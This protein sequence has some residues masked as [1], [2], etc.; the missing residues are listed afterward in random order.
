MKTLKFKTKEEASKVINDFVAQEYYGWSKATD[1]DG[2]VTW[3]DVDDRESRVHFVNITDDF[4]KGMEL[5][6]KI[7]P[8]ADV[9]IYNSEDFLTIAWFE[10]DNDRPECVGV[11][12]FHSWSFT[13]WCAIYELITENKIEVGE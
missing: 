3:Y 8:D 10:G 4:E 9:C 1:S 13:L 11:K 6:R 5:L 2:F 7:K 12:L